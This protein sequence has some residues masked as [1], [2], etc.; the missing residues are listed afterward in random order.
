[1]TQKKASGAAGLE[2]R[3]I[4]FDTQVYRAYGHDLGVGPLKTLAA[5]LAEG[6]F[7]LHT[8]DITLKEV[9][10]QLDTMQTELTT[11]ANRSSRLVDR[12]NNR[13]RHEHNHLAVPDTLDLPIS[14][15][16]AFVDFEWK[17][18]HEWKAKR[19]DAA[20]LPMGLVLDQYFLSQAPFDNDGSKEF[21]DAMALLALEAWCRSAREK[22]YVVSKDKAVQ[23]A[24]DLSKYLISVES[25][26]RLLSHLTSA[27]EHD[28]AKE[29]EDALS[30]PALSAVLESTLSENMLH[31]GGVYDGDRMDGEVQ[32]IELLALNEISSVTV[33]RVDND[34]VTCVL[35]L[36]IDVS[37]EVSYDDI[38]EA[39]W[40]SEDGRYYGAESG[41]AEVEN[42][43][44]A[45]LFVE[46]SRDGGKFELED[47]QFITRDLVIR[48]HDSDEYPYK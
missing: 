25:L 38:S 33:L 43:V 29:V 34:K 19:H 3:H 1:M 28:I 17:L 41:W 30:E 42:S 48:D 22:C 23:R 14:P 7:V 4:F 16:K 44:V 39:M 37:A 11:K 2:T 10:A 13:L 15:T 5:Y 35:G 18:I 6:V 40:D 24:A 9:S 45:K 32:G 27:Q 12:W 21:P 26:D 46:L 8:T 31:F 36:K 47:F 20:K